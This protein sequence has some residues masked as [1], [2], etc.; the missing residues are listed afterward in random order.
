M[1]Y[2]EADERLRLPR[3]QTSKTIAHATR[4]QRGFA[5][6][7]TLYY[8]SNPLITWYKDGGL[9]LQSVEWFTTQTTRRK[10]DEYL[11]TGWCIHKSDVHYSTM[12]LG[13]LFT[14]IVPPGGLSPHHVSMGIPIVQGTGKIDTEYLKAWQGLPFPAELARR[15]VVSA[16]VA[17]KR[18]MQGK[19]H[20]P[21]NTD[22]LEDF[23]RLADPKV[24]YQHVQ[25]PKGLDD[26]VRFVAL[27]YKSPFTWTE[28]Y[29]K[30]NYAKTDGRKCAPLVVQRNILEGKMLG[31]DLAR[32]PA[33]SPQHHEYK[34]A[35]IKTLVTHLLR[36]NAPI[37]R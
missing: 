27:S 30:E 10:L 15:T 1:N 29:W 7:I 24:L 9:A 16:E 2:E 34:R 25:Q 36:S 32:P 11:P 35:M 13:T 22:L 28:K 33:N 3:N 12:R 23:K 31:M 19:L 37:M 17:V 4:L 20:D 21:K 18:L 14:C 6:D 8:Q 5:G 26:A